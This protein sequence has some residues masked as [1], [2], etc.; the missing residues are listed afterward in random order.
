[1]RHTIKLE[2]KLIS[3]V[4]V[5]CTCNAFSLGLERVI[6]L[7]GSFTNLIRENTYV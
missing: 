4:M 5:L 1:M 2:W 7:D 6:T 3:Q